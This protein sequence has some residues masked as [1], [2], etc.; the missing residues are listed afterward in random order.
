MTAVGGNWPR[1]LSQ[2]SAPLTANDLSG[3]FSTIFQS[4]FFSIDI[5]TTQAGMGVLF[6]SANTNSVRFHGS[7]TISM[8]YFGW[9]SASGGL[10][11]FTVGIFRVILMACCGSH[12]STR[13]SALVRMGKHPVLIA[14]CAMRKIPKFASS[15]FVRTL[16]NVRC[17]ER[18]CTRE[19]YFGNKDGCT[20]KWTS[21]IYVSIEIDN[22]SIK[23]NTL[24][25]DF[26]SVVP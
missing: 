14:F 6:E 17:S 16:R 13:W 15:L 18:P 2:D 21:K 24:S 8:E 7:I 23:R 26:S 4:R 22:C 3:T 5:C 19:R 25:F 10:R 9:N 20:R 11:N 1:K 12:T